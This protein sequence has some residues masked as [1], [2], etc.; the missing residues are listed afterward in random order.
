MQDKETGA[1]TPDKKIADQART[2]RGLDKE[3]I[4]DKRD[5]GKQRREFRAR[6]CLRR[7]IDDAGG[8]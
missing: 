5:V 8:R 6:Q 1:A 3:A 4:A 2:W 7:V